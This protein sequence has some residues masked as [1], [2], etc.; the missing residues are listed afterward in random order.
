MALS[1]RAFVRT[2][3]LGSAALWAGRARLFG[4]TAEERAAI[5]AWQ[6]AGGRPLL[7]HN[8]ENPLGPGPLALE[9]IEAALRGGA[10]AG[11]YPFDAVGPLVRAIAEGQGVAPE[12]VV[13]GCGSTELLRNAVQAFT[14]PTRPLVTGAPSYEECPQYA[15]LIGTPVRAI[16]LDAAMR[17]DLEA[18]AAAAVG[19]GLVFVNNPNNPTATVHSGDALEA[20]L[21]RVRRTSPETVV[22]I[23]EAYHDYV[24]DP[25][26]R[27]L[28]PVA[29]KA[30][31]VLVARTFSKAY[32]MAGLRVGYLIGHPE[33]VQ[34]VAGWNQGAMNLVGLAAAAR[35]IRDPARLWAEA[36][37]N[38]EVRRYT[39]DWFARHGFAATA[40]QC[41]FIFV[42]VKRPAQVFREACR[43]HGV[44]VGRDFPPFEQTHVRISLGTM[45]EMQRATAVF[46]QVLGVPAAAAA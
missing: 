28:I 21:A 11:R 41:N 39:L 4:S 25:A 5:A 19:A 32:G 2:V 14:S 1:R 40:S 26:Y 38:T 29:V 46:A 16:P 15:A 6:A 20:F 42:N 36:A 44:I 10:E 8:N 30:P 9:A 7:L 24:T 23:D 12:S 37:R 31:G 45:E 27:T 43:A 13:T 34:A 18:M 35:S 17:L 22:L 33:T 3:G